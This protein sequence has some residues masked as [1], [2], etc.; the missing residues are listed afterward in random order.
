MSD[1]PRISTPRQLP[2][3][4]DSPILLRSDSAAFRL[5]PS[6]AISSIPTSGDFRSGSNANRAEVGEETESIRLYS[7]RSSTSYSNWSAGDRYVTRVL[8]YL[9]TISADDRGNTQ[10]HTSKKSIFAN[11]VRPFTISLDHVTS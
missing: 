3:P 10:L 11:F 4:A 7:R 8:A 2:T 1:S 5:S 6:A 9:P